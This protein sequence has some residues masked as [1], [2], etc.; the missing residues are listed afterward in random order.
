M[1]KLCKKRDME[2]QVLTTDR[3]SQEYHLR[4]ACNAVLNN[5]SEHIH[6]HTRTHSNRTHAAACADDCHGD[7]FLTSV[8]L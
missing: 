7:V 1:E 5:Q 3:G 6:I 2:V 8:M 4:S